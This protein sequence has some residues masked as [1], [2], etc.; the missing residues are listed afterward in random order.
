M[1]HLRKFLEDSSGVFA[2]SAVAAI[3]GRPARSGHLGLALAAVV[4]RGAGAIGMG[5]AVGLRLAVGLL[6]LIALRR[7]FESSGK[8]S[9]HGG[10]QERENTK[11]NGE[12]TKSIRGA[13][14]V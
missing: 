7:L 2:F 10:Y 8:P 5:S 14:A 13:A 11:R 1:E 4:G 12:K 9:Q 6:G 3:R